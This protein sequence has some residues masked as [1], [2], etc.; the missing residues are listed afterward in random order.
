[1]PA[2]AHEHHLW[3][4]ISHEDSPTE[5]LQK[6]QSERNLTLPKKRTLSHV[7]SSFIY[8]VYKDNTPV[9]MNVQKGGITSRKTSSR[10]W[11]PEPVSFF[12]WKSR[13]HGELAWNCH[14]VTKDVL[15]SGKVVVRV[16]RRRPEDIYQKV[17]SNNRY[18]RVQH[19]IRL[20]VFLSLSVHWRNTT[21][22]LYIFNQVYL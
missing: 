16:N 8:Q 2:K 13:W 1:M 15:P 17:T 3:D 12:F 14:D 7:C 22:L 9:I 10:N 6:F 20:P 19:I 5:F 11:R 21:F 18:F 4:R